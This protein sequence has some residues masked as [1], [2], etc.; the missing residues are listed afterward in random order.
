MLKSKAQE[1]IGAAYNDPDAAINYIMSALNKQ[2]NRLSI[3]ANNMNG[4]FAVGKRPVGFGPSSAFST[5]SANASPFGQPSTSAQPANPFKSGTSGFGQPSALGQTPNAFGQPASVFS[6][7]SAMGSGTGFGQPSALGQQPSAFAAPSTAGTQNAFSR[8]T[9][10]GQPSSLG[11]KPN[12]FG[13]PSPFGQPS[14]PAPS[15]FGQPSQLGAKPSPFSNAATNSASTASPF[16]A[17][18]SSNASG[19]NAFGA[20]ASSTTNAFSSNNQ[21]NNSPFAQPQPAASTEV[22]MD[23]SSAPTTSPFAAAGNSANTA[24]PFGQPP[25]TTNAFGQP[26]AANPFGNPQQPAFGQPSQQKPNPFASAAASSQPSS[27]TAAP[28]TAASAG[29]PGNGPYG[30]NAT[31]QH[32]AYSSYAQK[33]PATGQLQSFKGRPVMYKQIDEKPTPHVQN[34]DGT[35]SKIWFPDGAP[36]YYQDTEPDREYTDAEKNLWQGFQQTG[37]FQLAANGGGGMPL[38]PPMRESVQWDF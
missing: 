20:A 28:S 26:P 14:Q 31:R 32:P 19:G 21:P 8:G 3:A 34:M 18:A 25:S 11:A 24:G 5:G 2:P 15:P 12:P 10:F 13:T 30:P 23:S 38:A 16:S 29:P 37:K 6:Q 4:E 33:D 36:Q 9:G 17:F 22:S 1:K 35:A 27:L 7:P